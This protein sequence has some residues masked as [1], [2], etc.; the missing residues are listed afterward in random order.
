MPAAREPGSIRSFY[1]VYGKSEQKV[2]GKSEQSE[3][4]KYARMPESVL[5]DGGLS[6]T[7]RCVYGVLARYV[8]QGTAVKIGQ[9][10]I[11]KLLGVHVET[12]NLAIHEL[13]ERQHIAIR[14]EGKA[15][16]IYHL[17]SFVFGKKQRAGVEEVISSP[18]GGR[19]LA[20]VRSA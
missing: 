10:R 16:R 15:R 14:G 7:A 17:M 5:F 3:A 13:E 11:A 9:R 4:E 8:Y 19:R 20:T 2:Y 12:V 1:N 6:V 18:S